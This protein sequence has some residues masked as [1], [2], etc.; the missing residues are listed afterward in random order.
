MKLCRLGKRLG[1]KRLPKEEHSAQKGQLSIMIA[2]MMST[3]IL[4]FAFVV[5]TGML[6]NAK[7]NLQNA[8]DLAAYAGAS[9]QARQLTQISY[10]N[11]EM[12]RQWKKFLFRMFVLGNM[13]KDSFPKASTGAGAQKTPMAYSQID[14]DTRVVTNYGTPVTCIIFNDDNYCALSTLP[15]ISIP[16]SAPLDGINETLRD[17]LKQIESI[18]QNNC[19]G[20]ALTNKILNYYWLFNADPT[21]N[22]ATQSF[23]IF[24]NTAIARVLPNIT[25]VLV[26]LVR[27]LGIV[28]REIILRFRIRTLNEYLNHPPETGLSYSTVQSYLS[29]QDPVQYERSIQAFLSA[30]YTLGNHTFPESSIRMDELQNPLQLKLNEIKTPF[31][32]WALDM[33]LGAPDADGASNCSASL[34][35]F[36]IKPL[37]LGVWKDPTALTYYAVKLSAKARVLFSPFGDIEMKAYAAARPFGSRIGP[38]SADFSYKAVPLG[39]SLNPNTSG[40]IPNLPLRQD[41]SAGQ[42]QGWDTKEM[43]GQMYLALN[44]SAATPGALSPAVTTDMIEAAYAKAMAPNPWERSQYNLINDLST[45]GTQDSFVQNFDATEVAAIW[46][47]VFPPS[48]QAAMSKDIQSAVQA[49]FVDPNQIAGNNGAGVFTALSQSIANQLNTYIT[50][51]LT[52]PGLGENEETLTVATIT[53]PFKIPPNLAGGGQPTGGDPALFLQA[54]QPQDY[55]TSW[56][57]PNRSDLR[58]EGR[59]GYSVKFVSFDSLINHKTRP[60]GSNVF[61]NDI[62]SDTETQLDLINLKH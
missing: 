56:N 20:I 59:V 32:V 54:A 21:M 57:E 18:R 55:K 1:L 11:Y 40:L 13:S 4:L 19:N 51:N 29:S 62:S 44:P 14:P 45:N 23:S 24:G 9:V 8:A 36:S 17:Q 10:L 52:Q 42:G 6:I 25:Q 50:S 31:D 60:D 16:P 49:L 15:K 26:G 35:P 28:P 47:P 33:N 22:Q 30:Y 41:D 12:R 37:T 7:I 2:I 46:A 27:G 38:R 3:F 61:N 39:Q 48:K 5:N 43:M 58:R 34:V 53:N